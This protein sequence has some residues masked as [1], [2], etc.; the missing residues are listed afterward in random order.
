MIL[1]ATGTAAIVGLPDFIGTEKF[2]V[3]P[4]TP[5]ND[6]EIHST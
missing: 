3:T 4:D 1:Q 5:G 6:K 2:H